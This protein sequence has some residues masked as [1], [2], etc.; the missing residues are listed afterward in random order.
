MQANNTDRSPVAM[1]MQGSGALKVASNHDTGFQS[2]LS[3]TL[4]L[5]WGPDDPG[6][7]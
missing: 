2:P 4:L 7:L 6:T 5:P 3:L 1:D